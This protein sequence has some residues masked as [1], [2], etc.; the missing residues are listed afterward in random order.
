M[1]R[2]RLSERHSRPGDGRRTDLSG[3]RKKIDR[4]SGTHF[5][6]TVER[7]TCQNTEGKRENGGTHFLETAEGVVCQDMERNRASE[8]RSRSGDSRGR[9]LSKYRKK[10][11][12]RRHSLETAESDMS[13]HGKKPTDEV[14]SLPRDSRGMDLSGHGKKPTK[15]RYS[16]SGGNRDGLIRTWKEIE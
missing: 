5:L 9:D 2:N 6:E 11:A 12:E 7:G 10:P 3:R 15:R 14:H 1:G 13:G 16:L 4:L 8:G